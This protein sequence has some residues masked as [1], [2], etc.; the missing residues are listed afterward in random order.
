MLAAPWGGFLLFCFREEHKKHSAG[1]AFVTL[2][3]DPASLTLQ[4]FLKLDKERMKN[5]LVCTCQWCDVSY[6]PLRLE[7]VWCHV[8][9]LFTWPLASLLHCCQTS[10]VFPGSLWL[11]WLV[12]CWFSA[13]ALPET[14]PATSLKPN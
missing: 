13:F 12:L 1:C 8:S 6:T 5:A 4:E 11:R 14:Q 7:V 10:L 3:K 2:Q 9:G